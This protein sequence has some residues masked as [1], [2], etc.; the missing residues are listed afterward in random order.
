MLENDLV[1]RRRA[2]AM[3][4]MLMSVGLGLFL[5]GGFALAVQTGDGA[6]EP[7]NRRVT[8]NIGN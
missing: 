5:G 3:G 7:R 2:L 8:I 6:R 4:V 1:V